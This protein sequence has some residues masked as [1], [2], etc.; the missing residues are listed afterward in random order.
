MS[1]ELA[2]GKKITH[3]PKAREEKE[4]EALSGEPMLNGGNNLSMGIASLGKISRVW[5]WLDPHL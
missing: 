3:I 4:V 2:V 1:P 5:R